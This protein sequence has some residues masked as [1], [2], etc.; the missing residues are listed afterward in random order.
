METVSVAAAFITIVRAVADLLKRFKKHEEADAM[1][2]AAE[3]IQTKGEISRNEAKES[4]A[5]SLT[6]ELGEEKARPL[7]EYTEMLDTLFPFRPSGALLQYGTAIEQL[8]L[9]IRDVLVKLQTFKLFG[10]RLKSNIRL[11]FASSG[12]PFYGIG[13]HAELLPS[14]IRVY[15]LSAYLYEQPH[16]L[17]GGAIVKSKES[18]YDYFVLEAK[19][20][21]QIFPIF[22]RADD[23]LPFSLVFSNKEGQMVE[24]RLE[25]YQFKYC[26]EG[27][28]NDT[29][30]YV[31]KIGQEFEKSKEE[32]QKFSLSIDAL[33]Q[34]AKL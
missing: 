6:K 2:R 31:E 3:T 24:K 19:D 25:P 27:L 4:L 10:E 8:V 29:K 28:L 18:V 26:M 15:N 1:E 12:L 5:Q 32:S 20:S 30:Y 33:R 21:Q 14:H 7:I 13:G 17:L 34:L 11:E 9:R 23:A 22:L 16:M